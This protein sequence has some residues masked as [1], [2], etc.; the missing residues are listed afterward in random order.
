V[1]EVAAYHT[2]E[3]PEGARRPLRALFAD[4]GVDAI[5]FASG[6]AVRGLLALLGPVE[7]RAALATPACSIGPTTAA[8][9]R[10]AGFRRV[11]EAAAQS[12][13]A[14][15]ELVARVAGDTASAAER[16]AEPAAATAPAPAT[17]DPR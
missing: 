6:S 4:G 12:T 3:A 14:L 10:E 5:V 8:A 2:V 15:A 9:A 7:R 13:V 11:V 16:A 1:D 17:E